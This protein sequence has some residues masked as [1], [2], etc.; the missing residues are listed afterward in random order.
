[1]APAARILL[2]DLP[3]GHAF[4]ETSLQITREDVG[5]Y[6]AAVADTNSLYSDKGLAPPLAVAARALGSLL[7]IVELPWGSLHTGQELEMSAGVPI[8]AELTLSGRVAQRS[9]RGGLVISVLEFSVTPA[10]QATPSV[11]G[12]TTVMGPATASA[13]GAT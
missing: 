6:I 13:G 9:E 4:P 7:E 11:S 5:A 2:P 10:G 1:M 12:R 8:G 3:K